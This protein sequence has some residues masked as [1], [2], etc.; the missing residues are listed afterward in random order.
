MQKDFDY[1]AVPAGFMH[2]IFAQCVQADKCLR[3]RAMLHVTSEPVALSLVNPV[4]IPGDGAEC[5]HFYADRKIRFAVG[6]THLLTNLP[7][8][9]GK[10]IKRDLISYFGRTNFYRIRNKERMISPEEQKYIR[11]VFKGYGIEEEPLFDKYV[12]E[13]KW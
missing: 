5:P 8:A 1:D 4:R 2:C 11:R 10:S 12:E 9:K 6:V 3:R 7:Y 13:Y